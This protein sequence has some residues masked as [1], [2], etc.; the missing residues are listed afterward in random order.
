[1]E[2]SVS[3]VT[4]GAVPPNTEDP[5]MRVYMINADDLIVSREVPAGRR[6]RDR[7]RLRSTN[8]APHGSAQAATR[9]VNGCPVSGRLS[10]IGNRQALVDRLWSALEALPDPHPRAPRSRPR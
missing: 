10:K 1:V 5:L 6:E 3:V 7:C 8:C 2:Q 4:G 9:L